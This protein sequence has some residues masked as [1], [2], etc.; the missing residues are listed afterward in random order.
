MNLAVSTNPAEAPV[1]DTARFLEEGNQSNVIVLEAHR[2][3]VKSNASM[4]KK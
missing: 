2:C 3:A 4:S 1:I